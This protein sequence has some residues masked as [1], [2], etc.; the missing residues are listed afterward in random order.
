MDPM[1]NWSD[2]V[3]LRMFY[4]HITG[5]Q[6]QIWMFSK[7][8]T[9][10]NQQATFY[11]GNL[12]GELGYA[13]L[14]VAALGVFRWGKDYRWIGLTLAIVGLCLLVATANLLPTTGGASQQVIYPMQ[15]SVAYLLIATAGGW[16]LARRGAPVVALAVVLFGVC[17]IWSSGYEIM[18]IGP[19]FMAATFGVGILLLGGLL[20]LREWWGNRVLL[21]LAGVLVA[22]TIATN[23][24]QSDE[25]GNTVVEDMTV[26]MLNNLPKDALILSQ[27]WDFWLAGSFYLQAV[28]NVR[29]DVLVIDPELLRCSWYI[30][31]LQ[32][33]HPQ[34]MAMVQPEIDRFMKPLSQ[35]EAEEPYNP[36]EIEAAYVGLLRA[37]I[38]KSMAHRPVLVTGEVRTDVSARWR[39]VPY[40]LALRLMPDTTYLPQEFPNYRFRHWEGRIDSYTAKAYEL[41][42]RSA[43]ARFFYERSRGNPELARRYAQLAVSFNPNWDPNNIPDQPMNGED[44]IKGMNE[45]FRELQRTVGQ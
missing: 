27:Q 5:F 11:L 18:E 43:L 1:F 7:D 33:S 35:F 32:H 20:A 44:Q 24:H 14:A 40:Y 29:P 41:Y 45:F 36:A 12:P 19:Y 6:Y 28:E 25:R 21:P 16:Y 34:F 26:N 15:W 37:M 2:P 9:I 13:G 39:H 10:W 17:L 31:Q 23:F 42:A 38:D 22:I 4:R 3:T 30:K 8:P